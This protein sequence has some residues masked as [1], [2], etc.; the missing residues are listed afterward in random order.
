MENNIRWGSGFRI[1][2]GW[3]VGNEGVAKKM[4]AVAGLVL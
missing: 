1:L 3:L 2:C 4:E